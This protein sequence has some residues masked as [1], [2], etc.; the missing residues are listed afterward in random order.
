[1]RALARTLFGKILLW[2]VSVQ[3]VTVGTILALV[4]FYLP[5]S[6]EAVDNAFSL[7]ADTAVALFERFGPE[8]LDKFLARTGENTLLQL[9]L[10][11]TNPGME[12]GPR[13]KNSTSILTRGQTGAYCLTVQAGTGGL[14]ES[15]ESRRSRLQI[16]ILLELVSCA[17]L[18]YV[19]ARY[20]SRPISDLRQAATR[21]AKG[22]LT[23]RVGAKFSGR[24]DEAA[25]LV[26]EFDQMADRVAALIEAQ[27]RLIGDVSHEIK[28]P[29]ARLNMALGLARRD[30]EDYAPKQFERM[31]GEI[32]NISHLV[33]E[34]LT[35]ASLDAMAAKTLDERANL[36]EVISDVL[37]DIAYESPDR[38]SDLIFLKPDRDIIVPGD[39]A[40]LG[41]AIENVLRNAVFY[42]T[43]GASIEISCD[44]SLGDRVRMTIQDHGPGVPDQALPH[45]FDP[46]YRVDDAR[47]RQTGGTGIGLAICRRAVELHH[48]SIW[49][50]NIDPHGLA[51]VMDLPRW[52]P[53]AE[54]RRN[55]TQLHDRLG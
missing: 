37:A 4:T 29:L 53:N 26:R 36:G 40:L 44:A 16:T 24:H 15:P 47:T 14:P 45:L 3:L 54:S 33:R 1:M 49:A 34:L 43:P 55:S 19:I 22:D 46:F 42:T 48:G 27:R 17:G 8:A 21:L 31:Q 32:D 7:Y 5:A 6:Q 51:V 50:R 10:S 20:L 2:S 39:R 12:C 28:S 30:A 13:S 35:L 11:A 9:K 18:S 41:R 38:A 25:D 52:A 23:A